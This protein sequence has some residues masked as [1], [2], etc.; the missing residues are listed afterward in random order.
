MKEIVLVKYGEIILKGLNRGTFEDI[1]IKNMKYRIRDLKPEKIYKAQAAIYIEPAEGTVEQIIERLKYVFG[2]VSISRVLET[3]KKMECILETVSKVMDGVNNKTFKVEA[4][5][6]DK[7][8]PLKSP[9]I[10]REAGGYVLENNPTLKVDV[11]APEVIL[12]IE[13]RDRGAY[14]Y[15]EKVEGAKGMP[16]GTNGSATLLL[17]GGIDSPVAGYMMAK[18]GVTLNCV[19]FHSYPYTSQR[20]KNK[21]IELAQLLSKY[22][23]RMNLYVV[24]FTDIQL[25]INEKC[26]HDE[27]TIIMRRFMMRITEQIAQNTGSLGLI[28]GESLGQVASQTIQSLGVTNEVCSLP[29]FRPLIGFDKD[30]IVSIARKIGT[31]ETSILPYEDCCTVFVAKHPKTKP[32][33]EPIKQSESELSIDEL[34]QKAVEG[35]E[36]IEIRD[37][38]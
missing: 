15:H 24:P 32:R 31:F 20:A 37:H 30:D 23:G 29:V 18:R 27:G 21:V 4:K 6:S 3:E 26:P 36:L 7:S 19:H 8:F 25:K 1:L 33:L 16:L 22:C 28:T 17:S 34:V 2:I 9:D 11:K 5:R 10:C 38:F 12:N 14:I 35:A 13:I